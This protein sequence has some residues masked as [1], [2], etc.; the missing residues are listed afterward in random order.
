[1]AEMHKVGLKTLKNK[2]SEYVRLAAAGE[3]VVITDRGRAVA[4]IV[5]SQTRTGLTTFRGT[6]CAGG[7][8]YA[9]AAN[10]KLAAAEQA[11]ARAL[12]RAA[13]GGL[14]ARSGR[15]VICVDSSVV[16]ARLLFEARSRRPRNLAGAICL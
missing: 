5:S 12:V 14:G 13:N 4:E 7:L 2:L 15:S 16:L 3:T 11:G 6:R 9:G 10:R 8:A 1:M